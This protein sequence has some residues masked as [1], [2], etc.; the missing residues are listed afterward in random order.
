M[1]KTRRPDSTKIFNKFRDDQAPVEAL[2]RRGDLSQ[3]STLTTGKLPNGATFERL[4]PRA[5]GDSERMIINMGPQHPSTHGVL[6]LVLE[7]DGET[8]IKT[9]P[10]IGYLHTGMEKTMQS[11]P[12]QQ[13]IVVT[14]R[15]D[16][17]NAMGN[18]LAYVLAVE[19]LLG[20]E[21]PARAQALRVLV[22]ELNRLASHMVAI[23]THALDLGAMTVYFYCFRE[24][25]MILD[26]FDALC[27]ARLTYSYMRVGGVVA[28]ANDDFLNRLGDFLK[29]IDE[30]IAEYDYLLAENEIFTGRT[31]GIGALTKEE[32]ID[33]GQSRARRELRGIFAN[34]IRIRATKSMISI[35]PSGKTAMFTTA[36]WCAWKKCVKVRVS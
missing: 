13:A 29:I 15:F 34:R 22:A 12:Y 11:K 10:V 5:P 20:A 16:Y 14:D 33:L 21:I 7:L 28:D 31:R 2:E 3:A 23:G 32:V 1:L 9:E 4:E 18:N 27:G 8:V 19:K 17:T 26:M 35:F 36:F 30:R 24:R 6:R 25:E